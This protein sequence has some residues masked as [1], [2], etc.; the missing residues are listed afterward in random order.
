[1]LE[2]WTLNFAAFRARSE[3]FGT[4]VW[5]SLLARLARVGVCPAITRADVEARRARGWTLEQLGPVLDALAMETH[6]AEQGLNG[7]A[8]EHA[9]HARALFDAT[10][11][12][13]PCGLKELASRAWP[14]RSAPPHN[15]P[16]SFHEQERT[17]T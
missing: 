12:Y 14:T 1:M 13:E 9:A 8:R 17:S 3:L 7:G 11:E 5:V 6:R 16:V 10:A 2:E 4:D 15:S